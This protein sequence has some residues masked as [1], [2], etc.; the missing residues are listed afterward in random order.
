LFSPH[1]EG[2]MIETSA[3]TMVVL[4]WG[5]AAM[6]HDRVVATASPEVRRL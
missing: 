5:V 4:Y 6:Q 1:D 2:E 3:M